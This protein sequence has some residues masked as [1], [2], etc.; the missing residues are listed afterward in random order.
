MRQDGRL[1]KFFKPRR[2]GPQLVVLTD[3]QH[4][5]EANPRG[6]AKGS[7]QAQL[8]K[9]VVLPNELDERDVHANYFK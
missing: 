5:L 2:A 6:L 4:A 7:R 1:T 9:I 3:G 8:A